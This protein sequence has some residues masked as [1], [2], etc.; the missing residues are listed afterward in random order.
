MKFPDAWGGALV[1]YTLHSKWLDFPAATDASSNGGGD[2]T[3]LLRNFDP[4]VLS[5]VD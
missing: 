4:C 5:D 1:T 3:G 2:E